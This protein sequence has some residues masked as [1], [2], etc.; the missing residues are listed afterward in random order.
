MASLI[1]LPA[2]ASAESGKVTLEN[3]L[4]AIAALAKQ[5]NIPLLIEFAAEDCAYCTLLERDHLG[6]MTKNHEYTQKIIIRKVMIDSDYRIR[7]F[8]GTSMAGD[9]LAQK[10]GVAVTPTVML[11]DNDGE[12][13]SKRIVGYNGNEYYGWDLDKL[14]TRSVETVKKIN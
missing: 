5:K 4:Q 8:N 6:P 10:Y 12:R 13:L 2:W 3:D 7:D 11:F 14:I 9:D 1:F